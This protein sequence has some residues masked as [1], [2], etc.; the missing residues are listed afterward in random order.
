MSTR[1]E[2]YQFREYQQRQQDFDNRE[3]DPNVLANRREIMGLPDPAQQT[4]QERREDSVRHIQ[5]EPQIGEAIARYLPD[6]R[7]R[8]H[9]VSHRPNQGF[10][11]ARD[12]QDRA[13]LPNDDQT[14]RTNSGST[15]CGLFT[16][17]DSRGICCVQSDL[18]L[19]SSVAAI[20]DGKAEEVAGRNRIVNE[21]YRWLQYTRPDLLPADKVVT[22]DTNNSGH[23]DLLKLGCDM[24]TS[25]PFIIRIHAPGEVFPPEIR[26]H[27]LGG[28]VTL[29]TGT[30][31]AFL[32]RNS[33]D[34]G[35]PVYGIPKWRKL[36]IDCRI[37]TGNLSWLYMFY[38]I[39]D[40]F[41]RSQ[42]DI[43]EL[44]LTFPP[45]VS[46]LTIIAKL[47]NPEYP[48]IFPWV[49]RA[50]DGPTLTAYGRKTSVSYS[51]PRNTVF[52]TNEIV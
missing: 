50:G 10:V 14:F 16:E 19:L 40:G 32:H 4:P 8:S 25:C 52:V 17:L 34:F 51:I 7:D 39:K 15:G 30:D 38:L 43:A 36:V 18:D 21:S 22:V 20:M 2:R 26:I 29:T 6:A 44:E 45:E 5:G 12:N 42:R 41:G 1:R 47:E 9:L 24:G 27:R 48:I 33:L 23:M 3:I 35:I 31:G 46:V 11:V 13:C 28:T 49:T 37:G